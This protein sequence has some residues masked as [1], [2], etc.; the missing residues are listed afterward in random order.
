[1]GKNASITNRHSQHGDADDEG[2]DEACVHQGS[3]DVAASHS[4]HDLHVVA[5]VLRA[6]AKE[7][8]KKSLFLGFR[9]KGRS[10]Y[11]KA[12]LN[13]TQ[14]TCKEVGCPTRR[15]SAAARARRSS[16]RA[17][18]PGV[19]QRRPTEPRAQPC[20]RTWCAAC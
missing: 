7:V 14:L 2:L 9:Y 11:K 15:C 3:L 1:M 13:P 17:G 8:H 10:T 4:D 16:A 18:N 6:P 5:A 12:Q 19:G 20:G